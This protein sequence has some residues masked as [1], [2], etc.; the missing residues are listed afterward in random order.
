MKKKILVA[1]S[2]GYTTDMLLSELSA[3]TDFEIVWV[4]EHK[5]PFINKMRSRY[6]K[7]GFMKVA[8]QVLFLCLTPVLKFFSSAR[9]KEL[10]GNLKKPADIKLHKIESVNSKAFLDII[11]SENADLLFI[12]GTRIISS[13]ILQQLKIPVL[14]IHTGITPEFRGIHGTY[15]ALF[16]QRPDLSGVTL[17]FVDA[18]VDTGKIIAQAPVKPAASDNFVTYPLLQYQAGIKLLTEFLDNKVEMTNLKIISKNEFS[19]QW[20]HPTIFEYIYGLLFLRVK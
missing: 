6:K 17:H 3:N 19:E 5:I 1:A 13:K 10:T 12:N 18:G 2:E 11:N 4:I 14:N 16:K 15:W 7:L 20:Y 8:G 9:R